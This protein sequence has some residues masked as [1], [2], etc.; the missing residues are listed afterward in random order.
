M[1]IARL[2]DEAVTKLY[3]KYRHL[4]SLQDSISPGVEDPQHLSH[5]EAERVKEW[6]QGHMTKLEEGR[7]SSLRNLPMS[8]VEAGLTD[9]EASPCTMLE[10]VLQKNFIVSVR[11]YLVF[12][13]C[14]NMTPPPLDLY[15]CSSDQFCTG[16]VSIRA[17]RRLWTMSAWLWM[18]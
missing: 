8:L 7:A 11:C 16:W 6:F 2:P 13:S 5:E 1:F 15:K 14:I 17:Q 18:L 10:H 3:L 4:P 12:V 9:E